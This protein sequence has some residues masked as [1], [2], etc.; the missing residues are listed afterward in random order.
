MPHTHKWQQ[1]AG[2]FTENDPCCFCQICL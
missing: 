2:K 1:T